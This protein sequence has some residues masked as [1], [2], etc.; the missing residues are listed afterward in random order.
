[1][2]ATSLGGGSG[3]IIFVFVD[4]ETKAQTLYNFPRS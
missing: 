3:T 4:G 1:M 2:V